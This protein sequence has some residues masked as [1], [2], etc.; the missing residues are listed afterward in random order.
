MNTVE[1]E[2]RHTLQARNRI[3]MTT[4]TFSHRNVQSSVSVVRGQF[5]LMPLKQPLEPVY[6]YPCPTPPKGNNLF[7]IDQREN[8]D[9][10]K[11]EKN[12]QEGKYPSGDREACGVWR[13]WRSHVTHHQGQR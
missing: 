9:L 2:R 11:E 12:D 5:S 7:V 1:Q 3:V 10:S 6:A 8:G 4:G 13:A